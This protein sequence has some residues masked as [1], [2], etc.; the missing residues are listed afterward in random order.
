MNRWAGKLNALS[1]PY[2]SIAEQH[3]IASCLDAKA[4]A[5]DR[6]IA[7]KEQL[8][9]ETESCKKSLIYEVVTG[10]R[11]VPISKSPAAAC[12]DRLDVFC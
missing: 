5:I 7:K 12:S 1:M 10:K 3:R 11:E 6:L 4:A 2:P 9:A 8:A